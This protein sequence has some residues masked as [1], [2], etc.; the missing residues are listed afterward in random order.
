[1]LIFRLKKM[2]NCLKSAVVTGADGFIGRCMVEELLHQNYQVYA[3]G[4]DEHKLDYLKCEKL[5]F[6]KAF[7]EEYFNLEKL[8]PKGITFFFHFAWNGVFGESFKDYELQLS[9]CKFS[10]D[11][12]MLS[13][14]IGCK[15][16]IL[17]STINTLE[18]RNYIGKCGIE[19]RYTNIYATSKI[20][21]E[22][23]C[24]TLAFQNG[25]EFNCGLIAMVY[26]ENNGSN[27]V[28]NVV[29]RNLLANKESNLISRDILYDLI[30]VR[31]VARMFIAIAEKGINQKTYYV[32]HSQLSTFGELFEMIK[33]VINPKGILNFGVYPGTTFIDYSL[34]G[35]SDLEKD[36][37]CLPIYDFK[38]AILETAKWLENENRKEKK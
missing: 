19:P 36:T 12:L 29:M 24:K 2:D 5:H 14:K 9:N 23:I 35:V 37:G 27:M 16:F 13:K 28:P 18:T 21:A 17:A 4:I 38:K 25:I 32:G 3:I 7:F 8:L 33:E 30:Y 20:C 22:M 10:C 26:G 11:A 1:M 6:Y 15:K 34:I 31:D